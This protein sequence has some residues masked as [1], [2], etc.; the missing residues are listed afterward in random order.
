MADVPFY[1]QSKNKKISVPSF[2]SLWISLGSMK[3]GS[4]LRPFEAP[5]SSATS[6][7]PVDKICSSP[8]RKVREKPRL[9]FEGDFFPGALSGGGGGVQRGRQTSGERK[10]KARVSL[11]GCVMQL[12]NRNHGAQSAEEWHVRTQ[13]AS[14]FSGAVSRKSGSV[15]MQQF[16]TPSSN[17]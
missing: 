12:P 13:I 11:D 10:N 8:H 7:R 1:P 5:D 16:L 14:M 15:C 9:F 6:R 3:R 4:E 2:V 17:S